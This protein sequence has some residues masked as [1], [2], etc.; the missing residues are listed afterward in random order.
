MHPERLQRQVAFLQAH[1]EVDV[2]GTAAI[3]VDAEDRPFGLRRTWA[4]LPPARVLEHGLFIHPSI[5]GRT[6][7]FR[8]HP[9]DPAYVRAEDHELWCR[10]VGQGRFATL[11]EPLLFYREPRA[12]RL[13]PYV[14]S[15]RTDRLIL[16][17]YG[18]ALVGR[19]HT[20][21]LV[22][23]S[24][25]KELLYR[26]LSP[27]GAAQHLAHRRGRP[28]DA[29]ERQAAEHALGRARA[30]RVA[31]LDDAG[32]GDAGLGDAGPGDAGPG[33]AARVLAC[34][35]SGAPAPPTPG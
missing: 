2:V 10:T 23:K 11:D 14:S 19:A 18:P 35:A 1:P 20:A 27:L 15:C 5:M 13:G 33:D 24:K 8:A 17:T 32:L 6:A 29:G 21:R 34:P 3:E 28:L 7:W 26:T 16:R 22:A 30:A 31:G 12:F 9:Y 25:A 4:D